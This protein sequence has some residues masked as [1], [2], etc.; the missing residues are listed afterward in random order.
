MNS[1]TGYST[2]RKSYSSSVMTNY[3]KQYRSMDDQVRKAMRNGLKILLYYGDVD[4]ACNFLH[5]QRFAERLGNNVCLY[6]VMKLLYSI[7]KLEKLEFKYTRLEK[8]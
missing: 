5:G 6:T 2:D 3:H 1:Y 8:G 4:T 7:V